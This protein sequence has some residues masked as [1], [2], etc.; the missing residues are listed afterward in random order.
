MEQIK[1]VIKTVKI[2][3]LVGCALQISC[4]QGTIAPT[5]TEGQLASKN[6]Y[7]NCRTGK[8][9]VDQAYYSEL[10]KSDTTRTSGCSILEGR[11][12]QI[13]DQLLIL[14][15]VTQE[16]NVEVVW[17]G[18]ISDGEVSFVFY[19]NCPD[20]PTLAL[21]AFGDFCFDLSPLRQLTTSSIKIN[22][23][24]YGTSSD[25]EIYLD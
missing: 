25:H 14:P 10:I 4:S 23:H 3:V 11:E 18:I 8:F 21:A 2:L 13:V 9:I 1:I 17:N 19:T 5:K 24:F 20:M 15:I 6:Q 7:E 12:I 16:C 22:I